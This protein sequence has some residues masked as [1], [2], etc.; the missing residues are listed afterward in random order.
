MG[1]PRNLV[2][3]HQSLNPNRGRRWA[4]P[5]I[6]RG[7]VVLTVAAWQAFIEDLGNGILATIRRNVDGQDG[8]VGQFQLI[9]A[10]TRNAVRRLNTPNV[11]NTLGLFSN[12]G[13]DPE[14]HWSW[15]TTREILTPA[16]V[17]TRID[18]WLRVRHAIAH[19]DDLPPVSVL[20]RTKTGRPTL[21]RKN[22]E[23][24][25]AM[26]S[27]TARRTARAADQQFP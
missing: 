18:E 23:S 9:E 13:F 19:G 5:T 7:I 27:E 10:A 25:M 12:V 20:A 22:A 2:E 4:E 3:I 6:N 8:L 16:V 15:N 1:D 11:F 17:A 14:P 21:W 26:F 24:C